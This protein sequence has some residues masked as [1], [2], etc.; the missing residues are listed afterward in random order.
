MTLGPIPESKIEER[1]RRTGLVGGAFD[2]YIAVERALDAAFLK[3]QSDEHESAM[4]KMKSS[5]AQSQSTPPPGR[6]IYRRSA[7]R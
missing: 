3:W 4:R 1:A 2:V 6:P 7:K 5:R